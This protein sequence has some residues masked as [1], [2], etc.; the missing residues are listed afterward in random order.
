MGF[1]KDG[2]G[3]IIRE[4]QTVALGALAQ[5]AGIIVGTNLATLE[6]FRM[7]KSEINAVIIALTNGEG[8]GLLLFLVD[9][10]F[11]LAEFEASIEQSGPLGPNDS[12][13]ADLSERFSMLVGGCQ[14]TDSSGN[15]VMV[16]D[17]NTNAVICVAKPRW[18]FARTKSWNWVI[19]NQGATLT[20][21]STARM[22]MK[23]FGVWVT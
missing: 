5:N 23:H 19:Y 2:Q 13:S 7:L 6:R 18:T 1:G 10:D 20:T 15:D 22:K 9:G 16:R 21:G 11:S 8:T 17:A 14:A 4:G 12:V 3:V